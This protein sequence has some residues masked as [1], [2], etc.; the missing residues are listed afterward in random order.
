LQKQITVSKTIRAGETNRHYFI[1]KESTVLPLQH[2]TGIFKKRPFGL[3]GFLNLMSKAQ[4]TRNFIVQQAADVFNQQGYKGASMSDIM[5]ATHLKKGGIYNHF[6]SK[7]ELALAAFDYAVDQIRQRYSAAL[8]GKRH[9]LERLQA[10]VETFCTTAESPP[11]KGGCPM[12]NTAIESDDTHPALRDRTQQAMTRW[13]TMICKVIRGGIRRQ[14]INTDVDPETVATILTSSLEGALMMS[15]LYGD[16]IHLE[17][18]K[19]H[20]LGYIHTLAGQ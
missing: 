16:R 2:S 10:I 15:Q 9:A 1:I 13:Q 18:T 11:I 17:R 20:L 6:Q 7:D 19:F 4:V 14:E 3:F 8:C 12:L 5:E